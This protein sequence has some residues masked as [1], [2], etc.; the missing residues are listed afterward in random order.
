VDFDFFGT[1]AFNPR[2]LFESLPILRG[3][4]ILQME[5]NTLTCLADRGGPV[6]LS[7]FGLPGFPRIETPVVA[8]ESGLHIAS[9]TDLAGTKAAVVQQRAEAK[10]YLDIDAIMSAGVGLPTAL[11][12]GR[13]I[14]AEGFNPQV[15]LKALSY[16]K[17][18]DVAGIPEETKERLVKAVADVD[19]GKL[20]VLK[21]Q[22]ERGI[23]P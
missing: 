20:P 8:R 21:P 10:D 5:S 12:A 15:T 18:G 19:L 4:K 2:Q 9:L 6:K 3:A 1:H 13:A 11:A 7:F 17:D 16:F 14:Y 22:A 23:H